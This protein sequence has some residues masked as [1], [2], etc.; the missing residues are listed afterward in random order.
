MN[1]KDKTQLAITGVLVVI[2][3]VILAMGMGKSG[4]KNKRRKPPA[5]RGGTSVQTPK[6]PAAR[7]SPKLPPYRQLQA[8]AQ[9]M[10]LV[11]DPFTLK[12]IEK[13]EGDGTPQEVKFSL[14]GIAWD[15]GQPKAIINNKIVQVGTQL[16]RYTVMEITEDKVILSDGTEKLELLLE[17]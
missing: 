10:P 3:A 17:L 15:P 8:E 6:S 12:P 1:K 13:E 4:K 7:P 11:R 14:I 9:S 16:D 2:L 5:A